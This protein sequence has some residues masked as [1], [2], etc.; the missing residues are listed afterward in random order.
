MTL[1]EASST[2]ARGIF[3]MS[4]TACEGLGGESSQAGGRFIGLASHPS[5]G[6]LSSEE[7]RHLG[8]IEAAAYR[9]SRTSKN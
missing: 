4:M 9:P 7:A 1:K 6:D 3:D 2:L 5:S 8:T